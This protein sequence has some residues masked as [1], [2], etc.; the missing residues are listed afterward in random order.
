[1]RNASS[2]CDRPAKTIKRFCGVSGMAWPVL[3][4]LRT[5]SASRPGSV[6]SIV[7]LSTASFLV[8]LTGTGDGE[9]ARRYILGDDRAG[10]NP[11]VVADRHRGDERIVDP[12]PDVAADRR[13]PF[14]PAGLVRVVDRDVPGGDVRV[15]PHVRVPEVGEVR[16]LGAFPDPRVLDLDERA[17]F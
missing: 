16:D 3:T 1:M 5:E 10:C 9:R 13:P 11:C 4:S 2:P 15:V 14:R 12:G 8:L 17:R 7:L 6:C